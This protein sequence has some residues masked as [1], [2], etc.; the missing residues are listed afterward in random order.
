MAKAIHSMI[1]VFDENKSVDFYSKAFNLGI[2]DRFDFD[3]FTLVYLKNE[4]ND[5][6]IELTINHNQPEPYS[7]GTGYGHLAVSVD[8][9]EQAHARLAT[10][11]IERTDIKE[12]HRDGALM[13]KFFFVQDPDGY[14]IEVLQRHGRY[15]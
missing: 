3:G 10:H 12:F 11:G 13:A 5:F 7:H 4:E 14:K 8:D 15:T 9:I 1:R 6:E 2:K